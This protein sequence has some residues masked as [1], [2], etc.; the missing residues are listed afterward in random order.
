MSSEQCYKC[1][2]FMRYYTKGAKQFN[3]TKYGW[4]CTQ[5][6]IVHIQKNCERYALKPRMMRS[7]RLLR[8][9]LN[10]LLTEISVIRMIV[11]EEEHGGNEE[12][13]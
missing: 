12:E 1:K 10:G 5:H 9:Y 6:E 7:K 2:H 4:C 13:V 3:K 11:E 8:Y